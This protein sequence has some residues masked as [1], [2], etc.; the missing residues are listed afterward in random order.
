MLPTPCG[1]LVK[2]KKIIPHI[3]V[4]E[5]SERQDGIFTRS[6]F[7]W[8]GKRGLYNVPMASRRGPVALCMMDA[9]CCIA[10]PSMT[11]MRA[12]SEPSAAP[13]TKP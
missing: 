11:A 8:D 9:R 4:W 13:R 7:R 2:E 12:R 10:S 3:P 1:W 5:M 6:H